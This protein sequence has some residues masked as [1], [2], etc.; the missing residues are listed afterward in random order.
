MI[1]SRQVNLPCS[2]VDKLVSISDLLCSVDFCHY[3]AMLEAKNIMKDF[4]I[5]LF[6]VC[7]R[8]LFLHDKVNSQQ[9]VENN[10][11]LYSSMQNE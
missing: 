3:D 8:E 9:L 10:H 4:Q 2:S 1:R 6:W 11:N 5:H 7:H